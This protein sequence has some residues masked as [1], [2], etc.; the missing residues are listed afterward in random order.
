MFKK[1]RKYFIFLLLVFLAVIYVQLNAPDPLDWSKTYRSKDKIPFGCSAFY[2]LL[3]KSIFKNRIEKVKEN[4]YNNQEELKADKNA[5]YVFINDNIK[6]DDIETKQL[7]EYVNNGNT[8]LLAANTYNGLLAD[9]LKLKTNIEF[10]Y[11]NPVKAEG[12]GTVVVYHPLEKGRKF[13]NLKTGVP[14]VF[15]T[16]V[17]TLRSRVIATDS[18]R[19]P[20]FISVKEGKGE[21]LILSTPEVFANYNF[22]GNPSKEYVY[23]ILSYLNTDKFRFDE[24]YK[25]YS[26]HI[27]SEM[28]FVFNNDSLYAAYILTLLAIVLFMAFNLKRKQR[29][30]PVI[31]P[32]ANSTLDFVEVIGNVYFGAGNHKIIAEEK[33]GAFLESIRTKFQVNTQ[34]FSSEMILR[35]SS[36][37]GIPNTEVERLFNLI[38][39]VQYAKNITEVQL[40][41]LNEG[42]EQFYLNN[43]R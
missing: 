11:Y 25:T 42:I 38:E 20:V 31:T 32:P 2:E 19:N 17:D 28:Q 7:L 27:D 26:D 16:S 43:K 15:F 12:K 41:E 4:I 30:I 34:Y 22:A 6:F 37:S 13:Y 36:L 21:I 24:Y 39:K 3:E 29:A 9:T 10:S 35:I 14:P 23:I 1:N 8:L 5:T 33:I 40:I 18:K